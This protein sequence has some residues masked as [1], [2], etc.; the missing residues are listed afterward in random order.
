MYKLSEI[1]GKK[2]IALY[3]ATELGEVQGVLLD[4]TLTKIRYFSVKPKNDNDAVLFFPCASVA[5]LSFDALAL[6]NKSRGVNRF[7]L[8]QVYA[9]VPLGKTVYSHEGKLYGRITEVQAEGSDVVSIS[10]GDFTFEPACVLS[11]S[12]EILIVND[13]TARVR[14]VPPVTAVPKP[15]NAVQATVY[16]GT[17][18]SIPSN[19][20]TVDTTEELPAQPAISEPTAPKKGSV[21]AAAVSPGDNKEIGYSFLIGR[22]ASRSITGNN[23]AIITEGETITKEHLALARSSDKLVQLALH[24]K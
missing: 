9:S 15:E 11:S 8:P 23:G 7:S 10:A 22:V 21:T 1:L 14:L 20:E 16:T 13:G 5:S 2:A 17:S 12:D 24:S 19:G 4:K 18:P 6:K 3:E